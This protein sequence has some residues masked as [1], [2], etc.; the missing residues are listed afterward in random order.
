[1]RQDSTFS[2]NSSIHQKLVDQRWLLAMLL[3]LLLAACGGGNSNNV[4]GGTGS[5][6]GNNWDVGR[7]DEAR[8]Q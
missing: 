6:Q 4:G 1:M 8:W 3:L 7:W 5:N 2:G